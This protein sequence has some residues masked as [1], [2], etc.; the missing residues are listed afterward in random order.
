MD[1]S[2]KTTISSPANPFDFVPSASSQP[3]ASAPAKPYNPF[4]F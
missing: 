2:Q 3:P 4:D 1:F